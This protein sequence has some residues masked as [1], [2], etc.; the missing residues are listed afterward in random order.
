M[1][2]AWCFLSEA[3]M[4]FFDPLAIHD[5]DPDSITEERFIERRNRKLWITIGRCIYHAR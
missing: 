3:E 4:V 2:K 5:I 1:A